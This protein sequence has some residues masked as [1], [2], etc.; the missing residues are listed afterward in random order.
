MIKKNQAEIDAAIEREFEIWDEKMKIEDPEWYYHQLNLKNEKLKEQERIDNLAVEN[1]QL[2]D[3][4]VKKIMIAPEVPSTDLTKVAEQVTDIHINLEDTVRIGVKKAYQDIYGAP[5]PT[6]KPTTDQE[7][8]I[9]DQ[10]KFRMEKAAKLL[11]NK[12]K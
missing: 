8:F 10:L 1:Q 4:L 2:K 9:E 5:K 7:K 6:S 12:F 11:K 3:V